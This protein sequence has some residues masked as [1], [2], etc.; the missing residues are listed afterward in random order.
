MDFLCLLAN[1]F[2]SGTI[3]YTELVFPLSH[4]E[5][6]NNLV[7]G[8]IFDKVVLKC[9]VHTCHLH[10]RNAP[11]G[12][13]LQFHPCSINILLVM[14]IFI[15]G[16]DTVKKGS[17]IPGLFTHSQMEGSF[18]TAWLSF[19]SPPLMATALRLVHYKFISATPRISLKGLLNLNWNEKSRLSPVP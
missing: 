7:E 6:S 13:L 19:P 8:M 16:G 12:I 18:T 3:S 5:K 9:H 4:V 17:Q 10:V 14:F 11:S 15:L 2:H 1:E